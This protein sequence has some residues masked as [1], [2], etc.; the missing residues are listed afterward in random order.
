[1]EKSRNKSC[2]FGNF[3]IKR[4][5]MYSNRSPAPFYEGKIGWKWLR[6]GV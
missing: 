4:P 1:M 2:K 5:Q 6:K 3:E